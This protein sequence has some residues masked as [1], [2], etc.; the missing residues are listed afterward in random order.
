MKLII[1]Q[2]LVNFEM[3]VDTFE[4]G[5]IYH[6]YS[7]AIGAEKLFIENENYLFFLKKY[8]NYLDPYFETLAFCLIPNHFHLLIRVKENCQ[9]DQVIKAFG[10]FLNSYTKS[11]NKSYTRNGGLFQRKFKRKKVESNSY[12]TRLI[13][14]IH[15]N[16]I[17]HGLRTEPTDWQ[18]SS[19][20]SFLSSKPSKIRRDEVLDWFGD[21][22]EFKKVHNLNVEEYLPKDLLLE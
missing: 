14:Y 4:S 6:I 11:L 16:P 9:N 22:E 17:K 19:Y 12:Y 8:E 1:P 7:R 2:F 3:N 20:N 13:L 5:F 18:F 10:D 15:L 21:L